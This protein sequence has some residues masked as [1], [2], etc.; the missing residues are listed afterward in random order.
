MQP[1]TILAFASAIVCGVVAMAVACRPRRAVAHWAFIPGMLTLAAGS[2]F[3]GLS[4]DTSEPSQVVMWQNRVLIALSFLPGPWLL[5]SLTYAR[6]N[7]REFLK[8]WNVALVCAFVVPVFVAVVFR[9]DAILTPYQQAGEH[10]SLPLGIPGLLL[11]VLVMLGAIL[12][13]TNL[14]RTYRSA[15]GTMRWRIKFMVIGLGVIFAAQVYTGSQIMIFRAIDRSLLVVNSVALLV[16]CGL[17]LRSLFREGHFNID[18]YPSQA[19]LYPSFTVLFAGIYLLIIG[20]FARVVAFL[21]G[22]A[23]FALKA[24][25]VLAALVALSLVLLSDRVRLSTRRFVSRYFQRPF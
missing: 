9:S 20:V 16:G 3:Y 11:I 18:V 15:V 13:L 8:K 21:G 2:V 7:Y 25:I 4:L 10:G 23:S 24:F 6:G 22:D 17:I 19:V 5:F 12:V 1:I 14:E